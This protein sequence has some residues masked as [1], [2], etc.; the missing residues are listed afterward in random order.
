MRE[1]KEEKGRKEE[2]TVDNRAKCAGKRDITSYLSTMHWC[3]LAMYIDGY[4]VKEKRREETMTEE[5][6]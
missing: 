2:D 4:Q 3:V 5:R 6:D 1:G